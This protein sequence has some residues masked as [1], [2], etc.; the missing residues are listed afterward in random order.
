MDRTRTPFVV[1]NLHALHAPD[2]ARLT[3]LSA[4]C[5]L[6]LSQVDR[7]RTPFVIVNLHNPMYTSYA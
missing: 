5:L 2:C 4:S 7:T 3:D 1:V 6:L